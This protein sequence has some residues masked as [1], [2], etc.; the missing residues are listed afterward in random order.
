MKT[1]FVVAV[2]LFLFSCGLAVD[3]VEY[4]T[5]KAAFD[6]LLEAG[7]ITQE[8]YDA[9]LQALRTSSWDWLNA[10]LVGIGGAIGG[11]GATRIQ[12]GRPTQ[13]FGL[14]SSKVRD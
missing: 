9:L 5:A 11:W 13:K 3:S 8:Q 6:D 14:P 7:Q 2:C 1:I 4:Q 12:R 10:L